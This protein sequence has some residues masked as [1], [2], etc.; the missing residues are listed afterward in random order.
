MTVIETRTTHTAT[1]E[2]PYKKLLSKRELIHK[3]TIT[4]PEGA[5]IVGMSVADV[6][7]NQP[8]SSYPKMMRTLTITYHDDP[9]IGRYS[10]R[11]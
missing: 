11:S 8:N 9:I 6:P 7:R 4:I 1:L 5:D 3:L 10:R 2:W